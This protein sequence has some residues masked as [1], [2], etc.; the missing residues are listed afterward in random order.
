MAYSHS[1]VAELDAIFHTRETHGMRVVWTL[2]TYQPETK[3]EYLLVLRRDAVVR[4]SVSLSEKKSGTTDITWRM[5]FTATSAS[6][7]KLL[8]AAFSE[9]NFLKMMKDREAQLNY[10]VANGRM[11]GT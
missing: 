1:G 2:I 6:S 3:V 8:P 5:L 7:R 4:L 10:F 9:K 11:I